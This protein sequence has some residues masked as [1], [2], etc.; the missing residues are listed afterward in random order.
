MRIDALDSR[1]R[2]HKIST[3]SD[4]YLLFSLYL[5]SLGPSV[6]QA[7]QDFPVGLLFTLFIKLTL[8]PPLVLAVA[9]IIRLV[10]R[11]KLRA[12]RVHCFTDTI[13]GNMLTGAGLSQRQ[14]K[15]LKAY[16]V[17]NPRQCAVQ[18]V[19][20]F[21]PQ[22]IYT[23]GFEL[24]CRYDPKN[25]VSIVAHEAAHLR[26]R[27]TVLLGM[28]SVAGCAALSNQLAFGYYSSPMAFGGLL[29]VVVFFAYS[30]RRR[31]YIADAVAVNASENRI[32]YVIGLFK[33]SS[34]HSGFGH[35]TSRDRIAAL[36]RS[37]PILSTRWQL[38]VIGLALILFFWGQ[39][40]DIH[41]R[42]AGFFVQLAFSIVPVI[43]IISELGKGPRR[44]IPASK[45]DREELLA[46]QLSVATL[47]GRS[48]WC[49]GFAS[50]F[51]ARVR[52]YQAEGMFDKAEALERDGRPLLTHCGCAATARIL[53]RD[54][55]VVQEDAENQCEGPNCLSA[56]LRVGR[57]L[58]RWYSA[59]YRESQ[60]IVDL[61]RS[62]WRAVTIA[63]AALC[64]IWYLAVLMASGPRPTRSWVNLFGGFGTSGGVR[65]VGFDNEDVILTSAMWPRTE[66][67]SAFSPSRSPVSR[68][69]LPPGTDLIATSASVRRAR[70]RGGKESWS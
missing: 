65:V 22:L 8:I 51:A 10:K 4:T 37:S 44:K 5:L 9:G 66:G 21:R 13:I 15:S 19:G 7:S 58:Q 27:D 53:I 24:L 6:L 25:A 30:F 23:S 28:L 12:S 3:R 61:A 36:Y 32:E 45:C 41:D 20:F 56:R 1:P 18:I 35:P 54:V 60:G 31:E 48:A 55:S 64:A 40:L 47:S 39:D 70:K 42:A 67:Q 46:N 57:R 17:P 29:L 16:R 11:S 2:L 33:G 63:S 68:L 62:R 43:V 59:L 49:A 34:H 50:E 52:R 14:L 69:R 38:V 26:N